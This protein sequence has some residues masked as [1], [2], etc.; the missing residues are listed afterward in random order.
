V[1]RR[2]LIVTNTVCACLFGL[3][4]VANFALG[5]PMNFVAGISALAV[6]AGAAVTTCLFVAS[7][8]WKKEKA[9]APNQLGRHNDPLHDR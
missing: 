9:T 2:A 3:V 7:G 4:G 1:S 6:G 5:E 8:G